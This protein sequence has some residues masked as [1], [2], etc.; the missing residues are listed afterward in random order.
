MIQ[1]K[2]EEAKKQYEESLETFKKLGDQ[3]DA[4]GVL[5]WLGVIAQHQEDYKTARQRFAESLE[6]SEKLGNQSG[7]AGTLHQLGKLAEIDGNKTE[8]ARLFREAL[9]I[10]ECLKS[11][12]TRIVRKSLERVTQKAEGSEQ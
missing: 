7:I 12:D 11:P 2:P 3:N 9:E 4:A 1:G 8:A 5:H 6:I 10:L